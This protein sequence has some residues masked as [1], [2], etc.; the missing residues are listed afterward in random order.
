MTMRDGRSGYSPLN[1][2]TGRTR[3]SCLISPL[4]R[5]LWHKTKIRCTRSG[6]LPVSCV[7]RNFTDRVKP[8][9]KDTPYDTHNTYPPTPL[10]TP[11]RTS[12]AA[13]TQLAPPHHL[14][15]RPGGRPGRRVRSWLALI[16]VGITVGIT[17]ITLTAPGANAAGARGAGGNYT[18]QGGW[19]GNYVA[20]DGSR[21]Y[22]L[23]VKADSVCSGRDGSLASQI[24][25]Y[26][27][28]VGG[29]RQISSEDTRWLN[30]LI[31]VHGQTGDPAQAEAVAALVYNVMSQ[32][33]HGNGAHYIGS[34]T[35]NRQHVRNL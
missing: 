34:S 30:Y 25:P 20:G 21:V 22:C 12:L 15:V 10:R 13:R 32:N 4:F 6:G 28:S 11:L 7:C 33:H 8:Q 24:G 1:G 27:H 26:Q 23:D 19:L 9:P 31:S 14:Y 17:G 35:P 18:P 2:R 3:P 16:T 5:R 29:T